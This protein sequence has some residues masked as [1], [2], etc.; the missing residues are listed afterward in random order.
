M[1]LRPRLLDFSIAA[2]VLHLLF[3]FLFRRYPAPLSALDGTFVPAAAAA[4]L[5][6]WR[7]VDGPRAALA[8]TFLVLWCALHEVGGRIGSDGAVLFSYL[9]SAVLEGR[10][11]D[12]RFEAGPVLFWLPFYLVTHAVVKVAASLGASVPADGA[13]YPY[14][15]AVCLASLFWAFVGVM[16]S[17]AIARR[18]FDARLASAGAVVL[19]LASPLLW[20]TLYEPSMPHAV[21]LAAVSLFLASWLRARDRGGWLQWGAAGLAAGVMLSVQ[22]YEVFYLLLPALS[23]LSGVRD[24]L[25]D[26]ERARV[27]SA[28]AAGGAFLAAFVVGTAPLWIVQLAS[29]GALMNPGEARLAVWLWSGGSLVELLFSSKHGLFSWSPAVYLA[30]LGLLSRLHHRDPLASRFLL[31]LA[32]GMALLATRWDEGE[33]FGSRRFTEAFPLL[34]FGFCGFLDWARRS[35]RALTAFV[36]AALILANLLLADLVRRGEVPKTTTF[37]FSDAAARATSRLYGAVGHPSAAPASWWFALRY[38]VRPDR[39]DTIWGSRRFHDWSIDVGSS[40]DLPHLGRGWSV[41]EKTSDGRWYRWSLGESSSLFLQLFEPYRY[42]LRL[43]GAAAKAPDGGPQAVHVEVNGAGAGALS[44]A[45]RH[46]AE[47]MLVPAD[48]W[49]PGLN[50]I[51]FRYRY[52]VRASEAYGGNDPRE[53]ALRLERVALTISR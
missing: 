22:R 26:R 37:S 50:E 10:I 52:T 47:E 28:F 43:E 46:G 15:Q 29:R 44:F 23:A 3:L 21:A 1:T 38:G 6:I 53:I 31:T 2:I 41:S 17:V 8:G 5:L 16:L 34:L 42:R 27:Q 32:A 25:R 49:R 24:L 13:S 18:G 35:P 40:A 19:W 20:Y 11:P 51:V 14:V 7:R 48:Y 9:R 39:F 12:A 4:F 30:V 45:A 36:C 33:S